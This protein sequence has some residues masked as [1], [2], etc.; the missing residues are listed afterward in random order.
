[1]LGSPPPLALSRGRPRR[2]AR[3][4]NEQYYK[5]IILR[6]NIHRQIVQKKKGSSITHQGGSK[7]RR[8]REGV[9]GQGKNRLHLVEKSYFNPQLKKHRPHPPARLLSIVWQHQ[10]CVWRLQRQEDCQGGRRCCFSAAGLSLQCLAICVICQAC[11][12]DRCMSG[13]EARKRW[14]SLW[15]LASRLLLQCN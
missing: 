14:A 5:E 3:T 10:L 1:M 15:S 8:R 7:L 2:R 12:A 9:Q 11:S 6:H 4:W 13:S